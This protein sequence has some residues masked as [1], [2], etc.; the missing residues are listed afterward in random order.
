MTSLAQDSSRA[1]GLQ[2]LPSTLMRLQLDK[3][4]HQSMLEELATNKR[5]WSRGFSHGSEPESAATPTKSPSLSPRSCLRSG[6][7]KGTEDAAVKA[8]GDETPTQLKD[9][10]IAPRVVTWR[11]ESDAEVE[12]SMTLPMR[13]SNELEGVPPSA[14]T[15]NEDQEELAALELVRHLSTGGGRLNAEE[16]QAFLREHINVRGLIAREPSSSSF[17]PPMRT[18][19]LLRARHSRHLVLNMDINKTVLMRDTVSKKTVEDVINE[20]LS[21]VSWGYDNENTWVLGAMEPEIHRPTTPVP[22]PGKAWL[23]YFEWVAQQHPGTRS[24]KKRDGLC[25]SF[26]KPGQPGEALAELAHALKLQLKHPNGEE[27]CLVP[28][29]FELL[30]ALKSAG[31]S[32]S[33]IFRS[34]GTD[35]EQV[36]DELN[37][38]C[39]GRHSAYPGACFDG[40]DG[41][42]DLRLK[43][44]DP[45][46]IGTFYRDDERMVLIMGTTRQPEDDKLPLSLSFWEGLESE[47]V[48]VLD[49]GLKEINNYLMNRVRLGGTFALRDCFEHWKKKDFASEGGKV[50]FF[51]PED[52]TEHQ[53]F[54]DDNIRFSD[55]YIV[56]AVD[57]RDPATP[58]RYGN[59][60]LS[61][62]LCRSEPFESIRDKFYFVRQL[63]RLERNF[64]KQIEAQGLL[65]GFLP[66]L[67]SRLR[68]LVLEDGDDRSRSPTDRMLGV[69]NED[70]LLEIAKPDKKKKSKQRCVT[71]NET[72]SMEGVDSQMSDVESEQSPIS[73]RH[74]T[75]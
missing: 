21:N 6:N 5:P 35:I 58:H 71:R 15:A 38:F 23:S 55:P 9:S 42:V 27:A 20:T 68:A 51:N 25:S 22:E 46:R 32:F 60:L 1:M 4:R 44:P 72:E 39:E 34:F 54:F 74:A 43:Y 52:V 12:T 62:H 66:K 8:R 28:S 57:L 69:T 64:A 10:A 75:I 29:F 50:F 3:Q 26:T 45:E 14:E 61:T 36:V 33:L 56:H 17:P 37:A 41:G 40:S 49:L 31:R 7:S 11:H 67:A 59:S 63:A 24:K 73:P 47:G 2:S 65:R 16:E 19:S 70:H 13:S 53:V 18:P 48:Q 30:L